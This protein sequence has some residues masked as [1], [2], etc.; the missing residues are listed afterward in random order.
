MKNEGFFVFMNV[1]GSIAVLV[2]IIIKVFI[3]ILTM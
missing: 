2:L 1:L 3:P